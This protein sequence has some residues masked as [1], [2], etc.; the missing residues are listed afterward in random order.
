MH[1]GESHAQIQEH[2]RTQVLQTKNRSPR[3][4]GQS[5][6]KPDATGEGRHPE[7]CF[8]LRLGHAAR[9]RAQEGW[10]VRVCANFK[11]T[12]NPQLA[13]DQYPLP[14]PDELFQA[15][16]GGKRYSKLD[17]KDAFLQLPLDEE[18]KQCMT[19]NTHKGLFQYQSIP[20]GVASAPAIFQRVMEQML[21]GLEGVVVYLDFTLTA[22][23]DE[24]HLQR[25]EEILKTAE[26][27]STQRCGIRVIKDFPRGPKEVIRDRDPCPLRPDP[28][29]SP[30]DGRFGLR[31][32]C[33]CVPP[34]L[35]PDRTCHRV[36][37]A[38][39]EQSGKE[40][41]TDRK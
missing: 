6:R 28:N 35:G 20:F 39:T 1:E 26:C 27:P 9:D 29:G 12:V 25:L 4:K 22:S 7:A 41:R 36:G 5:G 19:I 13:I 33:G 17:L 15:L 34:I 31:T 14:K 2:P 30:S 23:S 40:L 21:V 37:V 10:K 38:Y 8:P 24:E 16:N 32:R 11:V 18:S 3:R